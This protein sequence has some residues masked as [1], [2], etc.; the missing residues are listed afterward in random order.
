MVLPNLNN[1]TKY[2]QFKTEGM[3]QKQRRICTDYEFSVVQSCL[4]STFVCYL[5]HTTPLHLCAFRPS[6]GKLVALS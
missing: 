4:S 5:L 2:Q 1:P 6:S 3:A